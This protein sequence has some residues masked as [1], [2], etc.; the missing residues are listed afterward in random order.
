MMTYTELITAR[1]V[2]LVIDDDLAVRNSLK[3]ALEI[4]GFCVRVYPNGAELLDEKDMPDRGCLVA[5]YHLQGMNGLELLTALR[6][7]DIKLPAILV[8]TYLSATIR[9]RAAVAGV[10][11]IEKPLLSDSLFQSIRAALS[12]PGAHH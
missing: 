12:E 11:L 1:P 2:V 4:E 3:F 8:T 9:N 7:R 5:D 10:L 6:N